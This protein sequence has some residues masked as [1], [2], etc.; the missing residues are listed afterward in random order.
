MAEN[1]EQNKFE[2]QQ[3]KNESDLNSKQLDEKISKL[4][5]II[6]NLQKKQNLIV[7]PPADKSEV[8]REGLV[9]NEEGSKF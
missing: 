2:M 1:I 7:I 9:N 5:Q 8:Y 4:E 6:K 3:R